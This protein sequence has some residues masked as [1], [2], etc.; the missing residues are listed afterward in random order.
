MEKIHI[1]T[2]Q[3]IDIEYEIAGIGDR[4]VA[5]M[6]DYI[7]IISYI[8]ALNM[9]TQFLEIDGSYMLGMAL[10]FL[11]AGF[12]H[13]VCELAFNGQ[14]IGKKR[15]NIRVVKLDGSQ[16]RFGDYLLRWL[17]R[18]VD[19][20]IST[21]GVAVMTIVLNGKGQRLGDM[22]AG[23]TVISL[24]KN[25]DLS[26]TLFVDIEEGYEITFQ[27]VNKLNDSDISTIKEVMN[28]AQ[29]MEHNQVMIVLFEKLK[30]LLEIETDMPPRVFLDTLVRDYHCLHA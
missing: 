22:A 5:A 8:I 6:L 30:T 16:V 20:M 13:L 28:Q 25:T 2:A 10:V 15:M 7:V 9:L 26:D 12:Y 1:Q 23:T 4:F 21:G 3:N 11:P 27:E 24:K 14:S 18:L 19:V 17:F 29:K